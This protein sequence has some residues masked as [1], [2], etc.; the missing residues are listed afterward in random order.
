MAIRKGRRRRPPSS[1]QRAPS[2]AVRRFDYRTAIVLGVFAALFITL[3]VGAFTR[4]SATWDEP[5]HLTAGYAAVAA[6]DSRIDPSHPPFLRMW[7]ALP[8][9]FMRDVSIDSSAIE[10]VPPDS[11]LQEAYL[12]AHRFMYVENDADRLLYSARLMIVLLGV[13]LGIVLFLWARDWLGFVPAVIALGCYTLEP[14]LFSHA[15]LV[16]TDF[17]VTFFIFAA[18]YF[19]R[20]FHTGGKRPDAVGLTACVA[21]AVLSKFS[22]LLLLPVVGVL[23]ASATARGSGVGAK[24]AL[25]VLSIIAIASFSAIWAAYGFRYLPGSSSTW[26]FSLHETPLAQH[27]PAAARLVEW[28]DSNRLLPNA[29]IQGAFYTHASVTQM[30]AFLNGE[31]REGGWWYYFPAA[32]ALKTPLAMLLLLGI[33]VAACIRRRSMLGTS[34]ILF[35]LVPAIAYLIAGMASGVNIGL[36]H[37]LPIY[38]FA[39]LIAAVG[40]REFLRLRKPV[41][42]SALSIIAVA[43]A[44]EFGR[45]YPHPLTFFNALA[46]GPEHG[47]RYLS[48]SNL[49]W[50]QGLKELKTWMDRNGV[51]Q[52]NLAYFG[53]ADPAYY[54]IDCTY[55]PGSPTFAIDRTTRPRLPGYVAI[56]PT[57]LSGVYAPPA[58]RLF[59]APFRNLEPEAVIGNSIRVY[60]VEEWPEAPGRVAGINDLDAHRALADALLFGLQWPAHAAFH[61]RRYLRD[62]PADTDTLINHGIA[63]I[64]ADRVTEGLAELQRAVASNDNHGR[65]QLMLGKALFGN[66]DL[67]GAAA[68]AGR[69]AVLLPDDAEAHYLLGRVRATQ[70]DFVAATR[71]L[72]RALA[73]QPGDEQ[74][75]Q[76]L[77]RV[78]EAVAPRTAG[79]AQ[80]WG[81]VR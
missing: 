69:A 77:Q 2:A 54:G 3:S 26:A 49:G 12:F 52:I 24:K 42:I 81:V 21:L 4:A 22:A 43:W 59:Y 67:P 30:P 70:G 38:P 33:G 29:F 10:H 80:A 78:R 75:Q 37:I 66:K 68:H 11:W 28:I 5:I 51:S 23:L 27:A 72:E 13:G 19:A 1:V 73:I 31:I 56:S 20:R 65:A 74:M 41:A 7:A 36:R 34:N 40:A 64:A 63:L 6:G 16:T 60:W 39:I 47:Y 48:D 15:S 79:V 45:A 35:V 61:Y 58:W 44:A 9:L 55:L 8:A 46:G 57:T 25:A 32:V 71:E 50:G 17:G 76:D 14:N 18:I 53:Q 62:R